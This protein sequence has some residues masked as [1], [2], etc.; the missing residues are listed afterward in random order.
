MRRWQS[1]HRCTIAWSNT[2]EVVIRL[3]AVLAMLAPL[4]CGQFGQIA[5]TDDGRQIYFTTRLDEKSAPQ[6]PL[7]Y[8]VFRLNDGRLELFSQRGDLAPS[9][10]SGSNDGASSLHV[11]G[12][13]QAVA[14]VQ[15]TLCL[16]ADPCVAATN[17]AVILGRYAREFAEADRVLLSRNGRLGRSYA[18]SL[19]VTRAGAAFG[20]EHGDGTGQFGN[21]REGCHPSARNRRGEVCACIRRNCFGGCTQR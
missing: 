1:R 21:G 11:S 2:L 18:A 4:A 7:E 16:S 3:M 15:N 13:G 12:D 6:R 14:F 17:R 9:D 19:C 8:R 10:R 20:R 5:V